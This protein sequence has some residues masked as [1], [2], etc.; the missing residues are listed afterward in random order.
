MQSLLLVIGSLKFLKTFND[1]AHHSLSSVYIISVSSLHNVLA[2]SANLLVI[3]IVF[4]RHNNNNYTCSLSV[5]ISFNTS[6]YL[7]AQISSQ[8]IPVAPSN[9]ILYIW[10]HY[11]GSQHSYYIITCFTYFTTV[12]IIS[13]TKSD[14]H[15]VMYIILNNFMAI[16]SLVHVIWSVY[17]STQTH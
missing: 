17:S 1:S 10:S 14:H 7:C 8:S 12:H 6:R 13:I 9:Y 2:L 4:T 15:G 16:V 3:T 11:R 5:H